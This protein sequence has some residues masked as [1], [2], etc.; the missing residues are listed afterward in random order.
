MKQSPPNNA[1]KASSP[2]KVQGE[3]DYEAARRFND[4]SRKFVQSGQVG[5]AAKAAAPTS[6]RERDELQRA[7]QAGKA[8]AKEEDPQVER[9]H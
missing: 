2:P 3:G 9:R 6:Q 1:Q 4:E 5:D 8:R 7:E